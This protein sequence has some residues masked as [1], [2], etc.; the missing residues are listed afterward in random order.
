MSAGLI[1]WE[2]AA[3]RSVDVWTRSWRKG[4]IDAIAALYAPHGHLHAHPRLEQTVARAR[5]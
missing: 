5:S 4:D 1:A 2:A 3:R